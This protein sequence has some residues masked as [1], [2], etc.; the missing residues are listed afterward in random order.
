MK[1]FKTA[2]MEIVRYCQNSFG[3]KLPSMLMKKRH[4]RFTGTVALVR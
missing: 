3:C 1:L 4:D 2:D